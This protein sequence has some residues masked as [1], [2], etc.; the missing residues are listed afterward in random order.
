[1]NILGFVG[2]LSLLIITGCSKSDYEACI[3]YQEDFVDRKYP[4]IS[5]EERADYIHM[6]VYSNCR[7]L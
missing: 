2:L 3:E 4:N 1:M 7:G 5:K 6:S